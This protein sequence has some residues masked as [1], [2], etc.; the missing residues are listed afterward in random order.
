MSELLTHA[1]LCALAVKWLQRPHSAGGPGCTIAVS[2]VKT[3]WNGEIPDAFGVRATGGRDGSVVVEVKMSRSDFL[4]DKA[5]PH[6]QDGKGVGNWRYFMCP[7]GV[8]KPEEVP[9]GWG[10]LWVNSRLHV[11]AMLGPVAE[12]YYG[13]YTEALARYWQETD[14]ER[15]RWLLTKLLAR[16]GDVE[17][18]NQAVRQAYA[19][20]S[21][22][23]RVV[24]D[25]RERILELERELRLLRQPVTRAALL[26]PTKGLPNAEPL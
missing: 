4:A 8:I 25:Q 15:E 18:M 13:P 24:N 7:A 20:Q 12:K 16:V 1:G 22:L 3:G 6:R 17:A 2:E 19:E 26:T 23:A 9:Q 5:K 10:L 21:R 14:F 11:K